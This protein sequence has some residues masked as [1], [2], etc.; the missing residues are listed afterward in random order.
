MG[1]GQAMGG[2]SESLLSLSDGLHTSES[3]EQVE[4]KQHTE[5][6]EDSDRSSHRGLTV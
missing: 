6:D 3:T 4:I 2:V 1:G 5:L